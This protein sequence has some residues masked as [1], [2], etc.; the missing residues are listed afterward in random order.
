M[1]SLDWEKITT[2]TAEAEKAVAQLGEYAGIA[3]ADLVA[4]SE[5][6]GNM[7]YQFI[8]A[9]EACID[10]CQH[11]SAKLFSE[12]PQSYASCFD[13]LRDNNIINGELA[14]MMSDLARFRNVIVHR[15]WIV[16]DWRVVENLQKVDAIDLYLHAISD[17]PR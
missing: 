16:D 14:A 13:V 11:V 1:R 17:M 3:P 5:K 15:Y 8:V 4:N 2:L 7:K 9:I 12:V 10:I 6:L